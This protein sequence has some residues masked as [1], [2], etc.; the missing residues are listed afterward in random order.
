MVQNSNNTRNTFNEIAQDYG[1]I[2][3]METGSES[4]ESLLCQYIK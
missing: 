1:K 4:I 3:S 2:L